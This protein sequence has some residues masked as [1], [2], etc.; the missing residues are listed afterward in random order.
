M[1]II[2]DFSDISER[3]FE[4]GVHLVSDNRYVVAKPDQCSFV[5]VDDWTQETTEEMHA[6]EY[7]F[8]DF[9]IRFSIGA[10]YISKSVLIEHEID[11]F[12]KKEGDKYKKGSRISSK[13]NEWLSEVLNERDISYVN[14]L[15]TGT[16]GKMYSGLYRKL[17]NK[18]V[19]SENEREWINDRLK[20]LADTRRNKGVHFYF[21]G[22]AFMRES[23][24]QDDF[25]P[26]LE[27]L[28][29]IRKR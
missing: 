12:S 21:K 28:C 1:A 14:Q 7:P 23:D 10:E 19:V 5:L 16:L 29:K 25:L 2:H 26:L 13:H 18:G 8:L 9:W 6:A 4:C 22:G 15:D 17:E 3:L 11:I 24:L 20:Q 27:L